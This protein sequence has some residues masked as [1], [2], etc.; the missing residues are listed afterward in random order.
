MV[1]PYSPFLLKT[2]NAHINVE[3]CTSIKGIKYICKHVNKGSDMAVL[4]VQDEETANDKILQ[5]VMGRYISFNMAAW[6]ILDFDIHQSSAA[7]F[8][9]DV[10]LENRQRVYFTENT[11]ANVLKKPPETTFTAFFKSCTSDSFAQTLLYEDVPSYF[12][13]TN[14]KWQRW[15]QGVRIDNEVGEVIYKGNMIDRVHT[16]HPNHQECFFVDDSVSYERPNIICPRQIIRWTNVLHLQGSL[17]ATGTTRDEGLWNT[18]LQEVSE[19]RTPEV[20]R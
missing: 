17:L 19:C 2:F 14:K 1:V 13:W 11:A 12:T 6:R 5:Y 10:H 4:G 9:L 8:G 18:A 3:S 20:M 7:V 15:R 16:V